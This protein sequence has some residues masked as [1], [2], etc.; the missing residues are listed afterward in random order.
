M[1]ELDSFSLVSLSLLGYALLYLE[2]QHALASSTLLLPF[3]IISSFGGGE[4][5][6]YSGFLPPNGHF[7]NTTSCTL[8][9]LGPI[10]AYQGGQSSPTM[11]V[12]LMSHSRAPYRSAG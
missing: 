6:A 2:T 7:L 4:W 1:I 8:V 3:S 11:G 9:Q 5:R 10:S 12:I